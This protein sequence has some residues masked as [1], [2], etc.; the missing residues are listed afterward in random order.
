MASAAMKMPDLDSV[1][2]S[3]KRMHRYMLVKLKAC[4]IIWTLQELDHFSLSPLG[5]GNA[6]QTIQLL[7]E[8]FI[9]SRTKIQNPPTENSNFVI[10]CITVYM[11]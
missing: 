7:N 10:D 9:I 4:Y 3:A 8:D 1:H 5:H 6:L 2:A 11:A